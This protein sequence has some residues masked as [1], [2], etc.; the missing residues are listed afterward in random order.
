MG[1]FAII[2]NQLLANLGL[3]VTMMVVVTVLWRRNEL[4]AFARYFAVRDGQAE[5]SAT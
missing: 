4:E 1:Y 5:A 3:A 2:Q